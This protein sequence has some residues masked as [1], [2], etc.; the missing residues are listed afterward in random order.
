[1]AAK[2]FAGDD[3]VVVAIMNKAEAESTVETFWRN[4]YLR[5]PLIYD[6][7]G[8]IA[9]IKYTQPTPGYPF[10]RGF[11]IGPDQTVV[12]PHFHHDPE[13]YIEAIYELLVEMSAPGDPD[14]DGDVDLD[15][16]RRFTACRTDP[17]EESLPA[18]CGFFDF[19]PDGDVDLADFA[20]FQEAFTGGP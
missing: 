2:E 19:E 7:E 18:K 8:V 12:L 14:G 10:G 16:L 11:V 3:R 4:V 20:A 13:V 17:G 9:S 6:P 15:D 1:M 5:G